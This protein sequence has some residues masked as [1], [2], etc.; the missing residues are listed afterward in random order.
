MWSGS[1]HSSSCNSIRPI[2]IWIDD[3]FRK[4]IN[5]VS[6]S[7]QRSDIVQENKRCVLQQT[8]SC[9]DFLVSRSLVSLCSLFI[10]Q[11]NSTL[12]CSP[13]NHTTHQCIHLWLLVSPSVCLSDC[14]S[15]PSVCLSLP[16]CY[17]HST[18]QL[19]TSPSF[20]SP[21]GCRYWPTGV[22]RRMVNISASLNSRSNGAKVP[23]TI[24]ARCQQ[25]T[26]TIQLSD[27]LCMM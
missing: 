20:Q 12:G 13:A 6:Y 17:S 1:S 19:L 3:S 25:H 27:T 15:G 21:V 18:R 11:H 2:A 26:S 14:L 5:G 4:N 8:K 10:S 22:D 24:T 23:S 9:V 16:L 7:R